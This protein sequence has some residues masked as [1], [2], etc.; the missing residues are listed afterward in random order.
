MTS[1]KQIKAN[2]KNAKQSTGPKTEKGKQMSSM[3][4]LSH[5][6]TAEQVVIE[7]EEPAD[8]EW[9]VQGL[10]DE[11]APRTILEQRLTERLAGYLWRLKRIPVL[12]AAILEVHRCAVQK[13]NLE[14]SEELSFG[15]RAKVLAISNRMALEKFKANPESPGFLDPE[16]VRAEEKKETIRLKELRKEEAM[17]E[18][19]AESVVEYGR[20]LLRDAS[21]NDALGKLSRYE[22]HLVN[23]VERTIRQLDKMR[24]KRLAELKDEA[25]I[26]DLEPENGE[27]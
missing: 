21:Q 12:E 4:A 19:A 1:E 8:F 16:K 22:V 5:G 9:V 2:K 25:Q 15:D 26:V 10:I 18:M 17:R 24:D 27:D 11:Y 23:S 7:G 20:A 6:L 3:N 13:E 14:K